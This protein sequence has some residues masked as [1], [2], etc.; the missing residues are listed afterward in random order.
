MYKVT[1][2]VD[3]VAAY[4][5]SLSKSYLCSIGLIVVIA[6]LRFGIVSY[7]EESDNEESE[8]NNS[9][10]AHHRISSPKQ[11]YSRSPSRPQCR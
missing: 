3:A 5:K 4:G 6:V 9:S 7:N 11:I 2:T 10:L 1:N 8:Y